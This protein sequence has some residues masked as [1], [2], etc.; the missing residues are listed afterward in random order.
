MDHMTRPTA[1]T[2]RA[3]PRRPCGWAAKAKMRFAGSGPWTGPTSRSRRSTPSVGGPKAVPSIGP[4]GNQT[5]RSTCFSRR[6]WPNRP[7]AT[8]RCR[9]RWTSSAAAARPATLRARRQTVRRDH[10]RPGRRRLLGH[11][12][13][14]GV[15]RPG[16][17]VRSLC[18]LPHADDG[19]RTRPS[20]AWARFTA[21]SGPSI[22][23]TRFGTPEQKRRFLPRLASG[24]ALSAFAL[25]EPCAGSDLTALRTTAVEAGDAFEITGEKLFITNVVP[26][27]TIG[28]VVDARRQTGG[29]DRR[30]AADGNRA[31]PHREIR[32]ARPAAHAQPGDQV[33]PLPRAARKPARRRR[34]ATG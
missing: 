1:G 12:H 7:R 25:T 18:Q 3:S 34:S 32:P 10:R 11:A 26:G 22:R 9:N 15:R 16:S 21:A 20:P 24:E 30:T 8:R 27:R 28:L 5:P 6:R 19:A 31:V 2:A 14:P 13:R 17:A 33:R 29:D 4:S 23:S